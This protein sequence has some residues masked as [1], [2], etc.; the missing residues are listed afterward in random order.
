MSLLEK[1]YGC[2]DIPL[3]FSA[4][5]KG[6]IR[7]DSGGNNYL[8][9]KIMVCNTQDQGI[10]CGT[11]M[12]PLQILMS[13]AVIDDCDHCA[14]NISLDATSMEAICPDAPVD[15]KAE[16]HDDF[17]RITFSDQTG[18]LADHELWEEKDGGGYALAYTIP[19][20]TTSYDYYTWQNADLN[21]KVRAKVGGSYSAFTA[22][23][24]IVSPL[25]FKSD[26]TVLNTLTIHTFTIVGAST[27]NIDWGDSNDNDYGTGVHPDITHDYVSEGTYFVQLSGDVDFLA[28]W[29]MF[30]QE[31]AGDV[32]KWNFPLS[33]LRFHLYNDSFTGNPL[34]RALNDGVGIIHFNHNNLSGDTS[35]LV[36]NDTLYDFRF[37]GNSGLY[38]DSGGWN[39]PLA[40]GKV[41]FYIE[42]ANTAIGGTWTGKSLPANT[43]LL[44]V[45]GSQIEW[46]ITGQVW[47]ADC[48]YLLLGSPAVP[49]QANIYGDITGMAWPTGLAATIGYTIYFYG[50]SLMG[51]LSQAASDLPSVGAE[52]RFCLAENQL[53]KLP[54]GEYEWVRAFDC[55]GNSC[56][57]AE[58]D[59]ILTYIDGYFVGPKVPLA[60][61]DYD[62]SGTGMGA[63]TAVGLAAKTSIINKYTAQGQTCTIN[64]N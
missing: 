3:Y 35:G 54:R 2:D 59:A 23:Q 42:F 32:T 43:K 20:G 51:D 28:D 10:A 4:F 44:S 5:L 57:T 56:N 53:T 12:T 11:D 63:P 24:N 41:Y 31:V 49:S 50:L 34:D 36:M 30:A 38:G 58:V 22:V 39:L 6:I 21:F 14:L 18:G 27:I 46:D 8:P 62:F 64:T 47:P 55:S 17:A 9:L 52:M 19:A 61:C 25:V 40:N 60:D 33:C 1:C 7:K 37:A 48:G 29:E 45:Y 15:F 26:Q 16:W 13:L